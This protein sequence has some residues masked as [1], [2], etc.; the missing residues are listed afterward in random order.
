MEFFIAF[1]EKMAEKA[2]QGWYG[3]YASN[4]I[5]VSADQKT[6]DE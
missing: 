1:Y 6:P 5:P 3:W 2:A 4:M